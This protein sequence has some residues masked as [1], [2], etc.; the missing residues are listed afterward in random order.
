MTP[1]EIKTLL[2]QRVRRAIQDESGMG[3]VMALFVFFIMLMVGS[4]AIDYANGLRTK[5]QLQ[6]VADAAAMAGIREL[7][8]GPDA[9]RA[10]AVAH[11]NRFGS[12]L[13]RQEDVLIGRWVDG[14]FINNSADTP[15]AVKV[16]TRRDNTNGNPL[17]THLMFVIGIDRLNIATPSVV[18]RVTARGRCSGGGY[19]AQGRVIGNSSNDYR[20]GF[21][22]HGEEAVQLHNNNHF[23]LGTIVSSPDVNNITGHRNNHGMAEAT[24]AASHEFTF[25]DEVGARIADLRDAWLNQDVLPDYISGGPVYLD[26]IQS[27]QSLQSGMLY[28]VDGDVYLRGNRHFENVAIVASGDIDI[29]SQVT[30]RN[31]VLAADGKIETN[32]NVEIGGTED[33][34]CA[35]DTYSAYLLARGDIVF[36]SNNT[37]RGIFMVSEGD[38]RMNSNNRATEG[39]YAEALGDITY[40]S[41]ALK[42]GCVP[43]YDNEMG[44]NGAIV[45]LTR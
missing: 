6:A 43:G 29:H 9:V 11:A 21:C 16:S 13:L 10:A 1:N 34:Y 20:D 18:A 44:F 31:V 33:D 3:S 24:R 22:V 40:N 28:I 39:L 45:R 8:E 5:A 30:L 2:E 42:L 7:S 32:S 37:L 25:A 36:N 26:E 41:S 19:F 23:E 12:N 15:N 38:I 14:V 35:R 27:N 4:L 17:P